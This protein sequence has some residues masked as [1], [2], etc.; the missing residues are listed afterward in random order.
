MWW[1]GEP[2]RRLTL[3]ERAY[4]EFRRSGQAD[5]AVMAAIGVASG[6]KSNFGNTSA[7]NG[8]AARALRIVDRDG[9]LA[10]WVTMTRA[11]VSTDPDHAVEL[12]G[13]ALRH[14]RTRGDVDLELTALGV[15][16][17]KLVAAGQVTDGMG[18]IDEAMA[19]ALAARVHVWTRSSTRAA[20]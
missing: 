1:L 14:G 5:R 18:C 10:G 15:L 19:G 2:R 12:A 13:N 8:W 7:A 11:Y 6:Y 3:R 4:A 20:T 17:E 16:G 9:P